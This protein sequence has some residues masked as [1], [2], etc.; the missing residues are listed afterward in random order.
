[1]NQTFIIASPLSGQRSVRYMAEHLLPRPVC[2]LRVCK[3]GQLACKRNWGP[4]TSKTREELLSLIVLSLLFLSCSRSRPTNFPVL[5]GSIFV[6]CASVC[7]SR[8]VQLWALTE[9]VSKW[10]GLERQQ[11]AVMQQSVGALPDEL[12]GLIFSLLLTKP[13]H[14]CYRPLIHLTRTV[15][16]T[17]HLQSAR[18]P[19]H[20]TAEEIQLHV[21]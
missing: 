10:P 5:P 6:R 20:G 3:I 8:R 12:L 11:Q 1:M 16:V 18:P 7:C 14:G 13:R 4:R 21:N 2:I 17:W 15:V 9:V 19:P